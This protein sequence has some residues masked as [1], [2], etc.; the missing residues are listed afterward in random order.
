MTTTLSVSFYYHQRGRHTRR[1]RRRR[2]R[3]HHLPFKGNSL[4]NLSIYIYI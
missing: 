1:R 3:R 2:R 4:T